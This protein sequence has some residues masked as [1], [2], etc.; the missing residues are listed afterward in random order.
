MRIENH[1]FDVTERLKFLGK[2]RGE[3]FFGVELELENAE[4]VR[5]GKVTS[6]KVLKRDPYAYLCKCAF[7]QKAS[8]VMR[9]QQFALQLMEDVC[10]EFIVP[11]YDGSIHDGVEW[12][13]A[14]A[15]L[16]VHRKR[17]KKFF[18]LMAKQDEGV[19]AAKS[20]SPLPLLLRLP[21]PRK[22]RPSC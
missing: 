21:L 11:K 13:S 20:T 18:D 7:C 22:K 2:P 3:V 6:F 16:V 1:S 15:S 4:V 10:E 19:F 12:V 8:G 17:W 14:P 9:G 5:D